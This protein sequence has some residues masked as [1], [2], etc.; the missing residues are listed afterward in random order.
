MIRALLALFRGPAAPAPGIITAEQA[1]A[2][3]RARARAAG[4]YHALARKLSC[5][6]QYVHRAATG[7]TPITGRLLAEIGLRRR[8]V[9]EYEEAG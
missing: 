7:A 4:G 9:V 2:R 3:L 6:V 5:S 8:V 1:R